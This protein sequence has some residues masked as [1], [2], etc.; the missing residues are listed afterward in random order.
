MN[1][2][3]NGLHVSMYGCAYIHMHTCT[4]VHMHTCA[5]MCEK[6]VKNNRPSVHA[7]MQIGVYITLFVC[8]CAYMYICVEVFMLIHVIFG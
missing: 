1:D 4:Y 7:Y 2:C 6:N 3:L 5:C 8:M